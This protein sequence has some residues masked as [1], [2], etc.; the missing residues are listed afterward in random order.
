MK[1]LPMMLITFIAK[2][3]KY[4]I[5]SINQIFYKLDLTT[6]KNEHFELTVE[7]IAL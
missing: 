3:K 5:P 1:M 7:K 2:P 4:R 6:N